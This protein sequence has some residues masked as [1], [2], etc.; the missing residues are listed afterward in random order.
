M[1]HTINEMQCDSP[2][3]WDAGSNTRVVFGRKEGESWNDLWVPAAL[4]WVCASLIVDLAVSPIATVL[5]TNG[6]THMT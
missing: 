1:L 2:P 4:I 5:A 6:Q 3:E